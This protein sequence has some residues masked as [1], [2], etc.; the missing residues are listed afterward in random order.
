MGS[1]L[2]CSSN[3]LDSRTAHGRFRTC[4]LDLALLYIKSGLVQMFL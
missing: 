1:H 3:R 4:Q 2:L